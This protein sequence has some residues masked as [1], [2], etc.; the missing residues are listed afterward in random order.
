MFTDTVPNLK[1]VIST[2]EQASRGDSPLWRVPQT[3]QGKTRRLGLVEVSTLDNLSYKWTGNLYKR[4]ENKA[5][6][7]EQMRP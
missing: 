3:V 5:T 6:T 2:S 4:K 7:V 1:Q